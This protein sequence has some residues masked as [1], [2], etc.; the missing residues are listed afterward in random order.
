MKPDF[1]VVTVSH[2]H[3]TCRRC[4]RMPGGTGRAGKIAIFGKSRD[5]LGFQ[6]IPGLWKAKQRRYD[7]KAGIKTGVGFAPAPFTSS[8]NGGLFGT[9]ARLP[10]RNLS[11]GRFGEI[12]P[13]FVLSPFLR[14]YGGIYEQQNAEHIK[15]NEQ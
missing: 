13:R 12:S 2:S 9:F 4:E 1:R 6:Q 3:R 10:E 5:S 7:R 15:I 14:F 11:R 8:R